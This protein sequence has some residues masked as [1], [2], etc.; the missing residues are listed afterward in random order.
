MQKKGLSAEGILGDVT[1]VDATAALLAR[2]RPLDVLST[3]QAS[4]G[5]H[6]HSKPS[7]MISMW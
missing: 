7:R 6:R 4:P 1:D 2:L 5:T 3:A